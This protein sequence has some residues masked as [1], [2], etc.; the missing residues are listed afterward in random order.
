MNATLSGSDVFFLT[1]AKLASQDTDGAPDIYDARI[2]GGFPLAPLEPV[3]CGGDP[4]R[5]APAPGVGGTDTA[6]ASATF[7]GPG[8]LTP[9]PHESHLEP[10]PISLTGSQKLAKA[11]KA[12]RG[13]HKRRRGECKRRARKRYGPVKGKAKRERSRARAG[14]R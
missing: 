7:N 13:K 8:N 6:P 3:S 5:A 1:N 4:C 9:P 2:D 10:K 11:L 14:G 12:C